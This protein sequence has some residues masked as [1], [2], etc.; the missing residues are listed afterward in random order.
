MNVTPDSI[1]Q[2]SDTRV[3]LCRGII[4]REFLT[5]LPSCFPTY[6]EYF[7]FY[8]VTKNIKTHL[9]CLS[10]LKLFPWQLGSDSGNFCRI[11]YLNIVRAARHRHYIELEPAWRHHTQLTL[12]GELWLLSR[13]R[14][15]L[16]IKLQSTSH[17]R[18]NC[19]HSQGICPCSPGDEDDGED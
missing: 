6:S 10:V 2:K 4:S 14:C 15:I 11:V 13:W 12:G 19:L 17:M 8:C 9:V 18:L 1:H 3:K 7:L 16:N 5:N